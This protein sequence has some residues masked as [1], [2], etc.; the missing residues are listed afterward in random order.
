[1]HER[2]L[3]ALVWCL[4]VEYEWPDADLGGL[5]RYSSHCGWT[6]T[7]AAPLCRHVR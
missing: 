1:M 2:V 5:C 3:I 7:H 4:S 6:E